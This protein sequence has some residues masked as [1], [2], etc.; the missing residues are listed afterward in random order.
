MFIEVMIDRQH[1]R[2][3][4]LAVGDQI[5]AGGQFMDAFRTF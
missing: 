3:V 5:D 1:F 2:I 4:D